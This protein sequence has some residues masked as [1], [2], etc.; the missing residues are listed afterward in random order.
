MSK[1]GSKPIA[2]E[3][4]ITVQA[5]TGA[6]EIKGAGGSLRYVL[7]PT[8]TVSQDGDT[9]V[10]ARAKEDKRTRALHGLY[11]NL[12]MNAVTGLKTPWH[13]KLEIVGTGFNAK[14]QG[15]DLTLKLGYS[16]P[17]VVKKA[18]GIT[19]AVEGNNIIV[20]SGSDK[21]LVGQTAHAIKTLKK[22]DAY[23]GKG[24]RYLGEQLRL[25]PGKKAKAAGTA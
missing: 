4:G 22:P 6:V 11:R 24:I 12:I 20:I 14:M 8:I 15:Q 17:V 16:H 13:K 18:E 10:V 23:K 5:T 2:V 9:V 21:Q 7:P 25:K 19:F 3:S 1:I